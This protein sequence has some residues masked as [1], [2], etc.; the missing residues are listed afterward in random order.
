MKRRRGVA[1][2]KG[3]YNE[4]KEMVPREATHGICFVSSQKHRDEEY[5]RRRSVGTD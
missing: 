3:R 2:N 4:R 5:R 1:R